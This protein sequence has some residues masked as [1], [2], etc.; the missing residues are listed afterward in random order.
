VLANRVSSAITQFLLPRADHLRLMYPGQ[1]DAFPGARRVPATAFPDFVPVSQM[2]P[3]AVEALA[4]GHPRILFSEP[5]PHAL[6]LDLIGRATCLV[7]PSRSDAMP[8]VVLEAMA[9]RKPVIA[10]EVDG[11]AHYL[12]HCET[13]L[14]FKPGDVDGLADQLRAVLGDRATAGLIAER[15]HRWVMQNMSESHYAER[16]RTMIEATFARP[17]GATQ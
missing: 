9:M 8:R 15:A 12:R 13:A 6:A 2:T 14:L 10:S 17:H 1:V 3:K 16:F 7:A 5:I 4:E 11:M